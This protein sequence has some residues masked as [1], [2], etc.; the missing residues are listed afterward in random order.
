MNP[1]NGISHG[2]GYVGTIY[3]VFAVAVSMLPELDIWFR[4]LASLSAIIA[5]WVSI[6]LMLAKLKRKQD[7]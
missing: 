6:F 4:I 1:D 5:A 7:K 2:T 3:S